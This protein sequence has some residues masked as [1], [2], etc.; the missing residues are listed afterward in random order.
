[1]HKSLIK[2][3]P[4]LT[5]K[6]KYEGAQTW[7]KQLFSFFNWLISQRFSLSDFQ[8]NF[9]FRDCVTADDFME[10]SCLSL[11]MSYGCSLAILNVMFSLSTPLWLL[12]LSLQFRQI[13]LCSLLKLHRSAI[14]IYFS[15]VNN[16][17]FVLETYL[18]FSH[19]L[20]IFLVIFT[21]AF[22]EKVKYYKLVKFDF[23]KWEVKKCGCYCSKIKSHC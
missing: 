15:V 9:C 22:Y 10:L 13:C 7:A 21:C 12:L 5:S 3:F 18:L 16:V 20:L 8:I 4:F 19:S 11:C 1:M 14:Y 6:C 17:E 2:L 23:S